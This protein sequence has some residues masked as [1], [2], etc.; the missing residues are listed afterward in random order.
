MAEILDEWPTKQSEPPSPLLKYMDGKVYKFTYEDAEE[1]GYSTT[2]EHWGRGDA[3]F[4]LR[5][6]LMMVARTEFEPWQARTVTTTDSEAIIFQFTG[7]RDCRA[8]GCTTQAVLESNGFCKDHRK[9][10]RRERTDG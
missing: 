9:P 1:L 4:A 6:D 10:R 8:T 3:M 2:S 5:N 7:P